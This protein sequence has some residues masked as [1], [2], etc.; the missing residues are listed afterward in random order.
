[1][2]SQNVQIGNCLENGD[3]K[4]M[5]HDIIQLLGGGIREIEIPNKT[6]C[7]LLR[8]AIEDYM[9]YMQQW[10]IYN[11]WSNFANKNLSTTDICFAL[12]NRGF[13]YVT[14][15][16]YAYSK[17]VGLQSRGNWQLKKDYIN[18]IP[19]QQVYE[20]PAGREINQVLWFEPS[21][22]NL[23]LGGAVGDIG[24]GYAN[25][26]GGTNGWTSGTG[27]GGT[28]AYYIAPLYDTL[29]RLTDYNMK[30]KLINDGMYYKITAGANG[31]RLLH[32]INSTE[33]RFNINSSCGG[34]GTCTTCKQIT[35]CKVWYHYY[36]VDGMT[37]EEKTKCLE[38][39][40]D[41]IKFPSDV[42]L[43]KTDF[44]NLNAQAKTWIRRYLT[45]LAKETLGK[46]YGKYGGVVGVGENQLTINYEAFATEG[47][48]EKEEL[49]QELKEWLAE[50]RNDTLMERLANEAENLNKILGYRPEKIW[51]F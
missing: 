12:T 19:N 18:L 17:Q 40:K 29:L 33:S 13:D 7:A 30:H 43:E 24:W 5:V 36:D 16:T 50:L 48:T 41:I 2:A 37:P 21:K 39:C 28:G 44:C 47:G 31:T 34:C 4:C 25:S 38:E 9:S 8:I 11:Q 49:K 6:W 32:L 51:V 46:I 45:A 27:R 22:M 10:L 26:G 3:I 42:P 15:F 23:A 14:E 35:G 20:L 1:M